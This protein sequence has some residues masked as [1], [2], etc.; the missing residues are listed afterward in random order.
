VPHQKELSSQ[1]HELYK[2]P[3]IRRWWGCHPALGEE[4][5]L[6]AEQR[7]GGIGS[8]VVATSDF[9]AFGNY[10]GILPR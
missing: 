4:S 3:V 6:W 1:H 5:I 8:S 2:C 10:I 7:A 9:P